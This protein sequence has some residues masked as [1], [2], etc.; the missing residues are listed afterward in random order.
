MRPAAATAAAALTAVLSEL[1][2][3]ATF[4]TGKNPERTALNVEDMLQ[5]LP[6]SVFR[7][8]QTFP[9]RLSEINCKFQIVKLVNFQ[10][11]QTYLFSF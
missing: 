1:D 9:D 8:A 3:I 2:S 5:T 4:R 7:T 10:I 6:W 11:Q